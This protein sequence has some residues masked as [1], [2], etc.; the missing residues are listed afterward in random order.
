MVARVQSFPSAFA[1]F[2]QGRDYSLFLSF[3]CWGS[4]LHSQ[5]VTTK[6]LLSS[7]LAQT[8]LSVD[9]GSDGILV[10]GFS[11]G[12]PHSSTFINLSISLQSPSSIDLRDLRQNPSQV[13][14][15][16]SAVA[17]EPGGRSPE[18]LGCG[19]AGHTWEGS[20]VTPVPVPGLLH[21]WRVQ[22]GPGVAADE[23]NNTVVCME[24]LAMCEVP[25]PPGLACCNHEA[26][27]FS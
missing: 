5:Q 1:K 21:S 14:P 17:P 27:G 20:T 23:N 26:S 19:G 6:C 2:L 4:M 16:H 13:R 3:C 11:P 15:V 18:G 7:L 22:T 24:P 25:H 8:I 12:I 10:S 9:R